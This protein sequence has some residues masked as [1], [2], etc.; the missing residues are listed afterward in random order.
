MT[1]GAT[2]FLAFAPLLIACS[3]PT[4]SGAV[5][6]ED[7]RDTAP[8]QQASE[9]LPEG[10][11]PS[12]AASADPE[13][14]AVRAAALGVFADYVENPSARTEMTPAFSAAWD[15]ALGPEG[16]MGYDPYCECQDFGDVSVRIDTLAISG[17]EARVSVTFR[18]FGVDTPKRLVLKRIGGTWLLDDIN[19]GDTPSLRSAMEEGEPGGYSMF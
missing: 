19:D 2:G 6:A 14:E 11:N 13:E 18:S 16:S 3:A 4:E 12:P 1:F 10:A 9:P 8:A 15:Y 5:T 17:D 7:A